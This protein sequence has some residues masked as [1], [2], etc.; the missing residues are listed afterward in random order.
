M[1]DRVALQ[2]SHWP[3]LDKGGER[4]IV[5]AGGE[6]VG[7]WLGTG[8]FEKF[9]RAKVPTSGRNRRSRV[10]F[11]NGH[12]HYALI[13]LSSGVAVTAARREKGISEAYRV[14]EKSG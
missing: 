12:I 5:T 2:K 11:E 10:H 4:L 1:K 7:Y 9:M 13:D 6:L 14:V 3:Y 8:G